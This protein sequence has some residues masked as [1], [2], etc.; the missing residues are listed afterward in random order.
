M[1][2]GHPIETSG[3]FVAW[4]CVNQ[5]S[6]HLASHWPCG[7]SGVFFNRNVSDL[8]VKS[9]QYFCTDSISL[10]STSRLRSM[11]GLREKGRVDGAAT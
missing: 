6:C 1:N 2:L 4:L 5:W 8:Y 9:L 11:L 3:D 10:D 7:I